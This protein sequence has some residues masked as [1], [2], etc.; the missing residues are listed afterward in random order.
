MDYDLQL[1]NVYKTY[2]NG[3]PAVIDFNID[4][5][6]GEFIA[7]LGPSGC[8]K[9]TTLRM[10]SGFE[11]VTKGDLLIRGNRVNDQLPEK[12]P[13]SMIFQNY[14]L[15]PHMNVRQN[16][17]FGLEVKGMPKA[18]ADA[19]VDGILEKLDLLGIADLPT[20]RLSG[21]QRQRIA[22]ARSLVVEPDIL[23]LDEPLGA[24]DANLRK[25][26]QNELKLLQ[27]DLGITFVFVTHAQSEA[28]ALSDRIVVMNAGRVEQISPPRELYT[29]P[30]NNFVARFIGSNTIIP[31]TVQQ[32]KGEVVTLDTAFAALSG[33]NRA[34]HA[35]RAGDKMSIVLPAE[36][37]DLVPS[38]VDTAKIRADFGSNTIPCTIERLQIVGHIMQMIV[39][40]ENGETLDVEG[41]VDKYRDRLRAGG[42]AFVAWRSAAATVIDG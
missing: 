21:G 35:A 12:R 16:V 13:T 38:D 40:L 10:I 42:T 22:L 5:E 15:F 6:K 7:F 1:R 11:T 3:T 39:R 41:H 14:A 27:R 24:L 37:V 20:A 31:G 29:R 19:K 18:E 26:I 28:L 30:S 9:S 33:T 32:V 2:D 23:L 36:A 34:G 25:S 8:G 4:V 17:R